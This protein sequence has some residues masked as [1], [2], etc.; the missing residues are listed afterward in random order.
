MLT[1]SCEC[2]MDDYN[3][4]SNAN[5]FSYNTAEIFFFFP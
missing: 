2:F 4:L 3:I 5:K 1:N